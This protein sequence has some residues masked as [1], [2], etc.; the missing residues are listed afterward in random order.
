GDKKCVFYHILE[1][2][3]LFFTRTHAGTFLFSVCSENPGLS[4][5][6]HTGLWSGKRWSCCRLSSRSAEGC[7]TCSSWSPPKP[8]S[9][10]ATINSS[11]PS[12][13]INTITNALEGDHERRTQQQPVQQQPSPITTITTALTTTTGTASEANN[14]PII[15]SQA[16]S[17]V[18]MYL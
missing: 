8:P 6:Y 17:I 2:I 13:A 10:N 18:G 5:R 16:R 4:G 12:S 1:K 7:D 3:C 11:S 9:S 15:Q 14:N